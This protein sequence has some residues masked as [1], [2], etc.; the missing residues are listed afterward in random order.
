MR[1]SQ[2]LRGYTY[3]STIFNLKI[4]E[5]NIYL[6]QNYEDGVSL[7]LTQEL[8]KGDHTYLMKELF[9]NGE[10]VLADAEASLHTQEIV[11]NAMRLIGVGISVMILLRLVI[12]ARKTWITDQSQGLKLRNILL[13]TF[14]ALFLCLITLKTVQLIP[15]ITLTNLLSK[16][17]QTGLI[18]RTFLL[19]IAIL[20]SEVF[21]GVYRLA[22]HASSIRRT[23]GKI[24]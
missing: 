7:D 15:V 5:I 4:K 23:K 6:M 1:Q 13:S 24:I 20:I 3:Y 16:T 17:I 8:A 14:W 22:Q 2:Q 21:V 12:T 18:S 19:N 11:F 9:P 10:Q